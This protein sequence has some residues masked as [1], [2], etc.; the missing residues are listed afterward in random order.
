MEFGNRLLLYAVKSSTAGQ[1]PTV[2]RTLLCLAIAAAMWAAAFGML[3]VVCGLLLDDPWNI[4]PAVFGTG[5]AT[6]AATIALDQLL[7]QD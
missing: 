2:R 1:A 7:P 5:S 4:V 6:L 3:M